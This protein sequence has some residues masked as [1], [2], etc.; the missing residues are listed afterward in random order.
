MFSK[1]NN[2]FFLFLFLI[3]LFLF[4]VTQ[5]ESSIK[6]VDKSIYIGST[7]KS[8]IRTDNKIYP[9]TELMVRTTKTGDKIKIEKYKTT[10]L[11]NTFTYK[12]KYK[13]NNLT[14]EA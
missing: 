8:F 1:K 5:K 9:T 10:N 3:L 12:I 4:P 2:F 6:T 13:I 11:F 14:G 7:R